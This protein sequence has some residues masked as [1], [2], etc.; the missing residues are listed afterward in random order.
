VRGT[1]LRLRDLDLNV[2]L[3][4]FVTCLYVSLRFGTACLASQLVQWLPPSS[5]PTL[6]TVTVLPAIHPRP[7]N[8]AAWRCAQEQLVFEMHRFSLLPSS[9]L[10]HK[11]QVWLVHGVLVPGAPEAWLSFACMAS[12]VRPYLNTTN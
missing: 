1:P 8:L 9:E 4:A 10:Y 11:E 6:F 2:A 12:S 3:L 7:D 5:Q